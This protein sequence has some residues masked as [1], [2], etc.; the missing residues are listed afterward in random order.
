MKPEQR[1]ILSLTLTLGILLL[2]TMLFPP[3]T[4]TPVSSEQ[5]AEKSSADV[6]A[7]TATL[8]PKSSLEPIQAI[9][10]DPFQFG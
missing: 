10:L 7:K 4:R 9:Q 6:S 2:W 3:S 1:L 8:S 5:A